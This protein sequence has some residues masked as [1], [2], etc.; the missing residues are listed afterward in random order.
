MACVRI[1]DSVW[2]DPRFVLLG[3]LMGTNKFDSIGR[4]SQVWSYCTDKQ[5]YYLSETMINTLTERS[6]FAKL[7]CEK[8]VEL[9]VFN[10]KRKLFRIR[11]TKGRIEWLSSWRKNSE[12]GGAKTKA[13]WQAK[14]LAKQEPEMRANEGFLITPTLTVTPTSLEKNIDPK[15]QLSEENKTRALGAW[16]YVLAHFKTSRECR[17]SEKETLFRWV[18]REGINSVE[19]ALRGAREEKGSADFNPAQ[20]LKLTRYL[21]GKDFERFLNLGVQAWHREQNK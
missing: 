13:N 16:E 21:N 19:I 12:K 11:G 18:Q 5:T 3:K 15:F 14:K 9:A 20:F 2:T 6:D 4:V 7:L 8:D 1:E 10:E 17:A